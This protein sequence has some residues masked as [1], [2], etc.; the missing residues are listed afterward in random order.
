MLNAFTPRRTPL[1][2]HHVTPILLILL[3]I[4]FS[5]PSYADETP[6]YWQDGFTLPGID[7]RGQGDGVR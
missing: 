1:R 2:V 4:I 5:G 3:C 7:G 6:G